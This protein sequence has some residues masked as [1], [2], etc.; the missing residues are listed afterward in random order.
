[1]EENRTDRHRVT[2]GMSKLLLILLVLC[3]LAASIPAVTASTGEPTI[4]VARWN[5]DSWRLYLL[6]SDKEGNRE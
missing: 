4:T 3:M 6:D 5:E 1:M 2:V